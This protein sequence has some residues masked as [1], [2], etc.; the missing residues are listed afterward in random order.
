[1]DSE[2]GVVH[3]SIRFPHE[4]AETI[5]RLAQEHDRSINGEVVRA[6]REYITRQQKQ[7]TQDGEGEQP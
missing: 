7:R 6:I 1:M 5:R 3:I 2:R 4:I